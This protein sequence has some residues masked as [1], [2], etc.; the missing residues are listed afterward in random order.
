LEQIQIDFLS[1][2]FL[3][4]GIAPN[5]KKIS[6]PYTLPGDIVSVELIKK[7]SRPN[8]YRL[9]DFIH[10]NSWSDARCSYFGECGGCAGQHIAYSEQC[11]VKFSPLKKA[12]SEVL[13]I[14]LQSQSASE[15][16]HYR[17]RMDFSV[18]PGPKIGLRAR[19][20]FRRIIDINFCHIQS[21]FA[22]TEL[23]NVRKLLAEFSHYPWDRRSEAGGLKYVTLRKAKF[24]D[25]NISIFTFTEGFE[26]TDDFDA[27]CKRTLELLNGQ[28]IIFC[29]NRVK[30]E[31]SAMG[32]AQVL[33]G[34]DSF[35]ENIMGTTFQVPFD[36]FFQPN[37]AGFLPIL[38]FI[39]SRL[40]ESKTS[41]T[42]LFCG[43]G[44]FAT[45]LGTEFSKINGY[46]LT[47]SSIEIAKKTL[48][49]I[50]PTKTTNASVV[51]LFQNTEGIEADA[52]GVLVLDPPR[53]GAGA[54]VNQW[55]KEFGP[56]DVFY[57]SCNPYSQ[58]E[59]TKQ[60]ISHYD[61]L[62]CLLIDPYPHTPHCE[63]VIH[64]RRKS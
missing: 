15:I 55:I 14:S 48:L 35:T 22:N 5:G 45:I 57:V 7:R 42:D 4:V 25:D 44:F 54:K 9:V 47:P 37:P 10:K 40:P 24:T 17:S 38:D 61:A 49:E 21:E 27:F 1:S 11:E 18:F 30:S 52:D 56:R 19:G 36:S 41:L 32:R 50:F 2:D 39:K 33:K 12:F 23:E 58:L 62:D 29:F 26:T 53:A 20:D 13:G 31:V 59:D 51:N 8:R 3:G 64:L 46:E 63:S 60:F 34:K 28:N 43:N 16:Y 6:Y